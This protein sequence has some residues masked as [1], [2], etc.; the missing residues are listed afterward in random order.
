[1]TCSAP[2]LSGA[3]PDEDAM[4]AEMSAG[5]CTPNGPLRGSE[6]TAGEGLSHEPLRQALEAHLQGAPL[7]LA[8]LQSGLPDHPQSHPSEGPSGPADVPSAC[9]GGSKARRRK[10]S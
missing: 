10:G 8:A 9:K 5:L 6:P 3:D 2:I 4:F 7:R 1:M